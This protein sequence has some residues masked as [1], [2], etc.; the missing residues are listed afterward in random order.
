MF[1]PKSYREACDKM[2]IDAGKLEEMIAM[3]EQTSKKAFRR[4]A[5]VAL[6][7]AA[8]AAALGIT[9]SAAEL[10]AVQEFFASIFVTVSTSDGTFGDLAVPAMAVEKRE[11][12]TILLLDQ[13]ETDVTDALVKDGEY[14]YEGD[15]YQVHVDADG[16]AVLTA[17]STDGETVLSFST[18]PDAGEGPVSYNVMAEGDVDPEVQTGIYNI[19]TD[20]AGSVDV[21]D[22]EG[23][24]QSYRMEDGELVPAK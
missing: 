14:V 20:D 24:V 17:Y 10:P 19:V 21:I 7:A 6:V 4:P 2:T 5:R 1:D 11:G 16:V 13:E 15:G 9:A 3:T 12:R 22:Q 8:L 18:G 23:Q